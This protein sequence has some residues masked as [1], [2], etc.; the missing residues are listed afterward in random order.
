MIG[1]LG[2]RALLAESKATLHTAL[3][4]CV[5]RS[6]GAL[7]GTLVLLFAFQERAY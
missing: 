3:N 6:V 5:P 2:R 1:Q 4:A 7:P